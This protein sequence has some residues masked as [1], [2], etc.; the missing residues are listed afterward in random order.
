MDEADESLREVAR[1]AGS[2]ALSGLDVTKNASSP[3]YQ[4]APKYETTAHLGG[5]FGE[6]GYVAVRDATA[7]KG[8][9]SGVGSFA[10]SIRVVKQEVKAL[11]AEQKLLAKEAKA[12][13]AEERFV[14]KTARRGERAGEARERLRDAQGRFVTDPENPPS[15]FE[16]TDSQRRR[17][18][19]R[20][21]EDPNSGLTSAERAEVRQRGFRGPQRVNEYNELETMELSHEPT[22]L[23]EGGTAVVPRWPPDHAAVDPQRKLK[24][25]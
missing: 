12:L 5:Q 3:Q 21:V 2:E 15:P 24:T 10:G 18:W 19:R 9:A 6:A 20:I 14:A 25:R 1:Y 4:Q 7:T 22:P 23:R 8:F 16:V 13:A 11:A 17:E